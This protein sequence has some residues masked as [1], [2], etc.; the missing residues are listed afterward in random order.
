MHPEPI[1]ALQID[2]FG[3]L[4]RIKCFEKCL[5]ICV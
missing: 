5:R 2:L 1:G 3:E 4:T